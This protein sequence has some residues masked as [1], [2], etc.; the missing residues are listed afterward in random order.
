[1]LHYEVNLRRE[2]KKQFC[3]LGAVYSGPVRL[4]EKSWLKLLLVDLL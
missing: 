3:A 2:K 1:V 4:A